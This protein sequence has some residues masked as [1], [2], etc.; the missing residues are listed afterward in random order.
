[1]PGPK[2]GKGG[3]GEWGEG[4]GDFWDSIGNKNK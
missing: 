1:M 2:S 4:M 3:V